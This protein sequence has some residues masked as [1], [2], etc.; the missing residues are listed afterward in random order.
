MIIRLAEP[1]MRFK[2]FGKFFY[3]SDLAQVDLSTFH[4]VSTIFL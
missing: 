3:E 2:L 1:F 4:L